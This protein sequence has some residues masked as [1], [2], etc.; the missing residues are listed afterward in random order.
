[1][2]LVV[3]TLLGAFVVDVAV[4]DDVLEFRMCSGISIDCRLGLVESS[5]MRKNQSII[6]T[7]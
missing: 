3:V 1:M 6:V 7:L 5:E 2:V 4:L